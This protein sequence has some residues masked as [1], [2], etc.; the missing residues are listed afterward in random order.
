MFRDPK[1]CSHCGGHI[2]KGKFSWVDKFNDFTGE[3]EINT[4]Y[5]YMCENTEKADCRIGVN[6]HT[7]SPA[8]MSVKHFIPL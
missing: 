4:R 7:I 2:L 6:W 1:F 3:K 5:G 8:F